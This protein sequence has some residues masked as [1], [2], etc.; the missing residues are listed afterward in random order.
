MLIQFILLAL[1]WGSGFLFLKVALEGLS[2]V[3]VV[4]GRMVVG[5]TALLVMVAVTR[6]RLPRDAVVW[7][8]LAVVAMLLNVVP[9][10]LFSWAELHVSSG[11][12]SIYNATTPLMTM[13]VALVALP[14]ERPSPIKLAGLGM[15]FA[16]VV[17]VL[18]PWRGVGGAEGAAQAALL[19]ATFCYGL[20]FAYLRRFISPRGLPALPVAGTQVGLGAMIMLLSAPFTAISPVHPSWRVALSIAALG[21]GSTGLA[22]VWNTNIVAA[23]GATNAA[24]VTYLSPVVGV[25]LGIVMLGEAVSWNEPLGALIVVAGIGVSQGRIRARRGPADGERAAAGPVATPGPVR[26]GR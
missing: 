3:Q 13:M 7:G 17:I 23:W 22:Y 14:D 15:G 11:L 9:F 2:P 6:Q 4:L 5:A 26:A 1:T 16:G 20:A 10:L 8:H 21:V 12:A 24:T 25:T 19:L 18:G